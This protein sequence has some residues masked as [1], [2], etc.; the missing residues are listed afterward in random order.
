MKAPSLTLWLVMFLATAHRPAAAQ[1]KADADSSA[2]RGFMDKVQQAYANARYLR[3]HVAYR[4]ANQGQPNHYLDSLSGEIEMD[5]GRSRTVLDGMETVSNGRYIIQVMPESR[6]I[7]LAPKSSGSASVPAPVASAQNPMP[8]LDSL[9][10]QVRGIRATLTNSDGADVFTLDLPAGQPYSRLRLMIDD[11]TGYFREVTYDLNTASL[12]GEDMID[13]PGHPAP[14]QSRGRIQILFSEYRRGQ[15]DDR[16]FSENNFFTR[17]A[18]HY[19]P[20]GRY[21]DYHIYL[22]SSNL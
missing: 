16:I 10:A 19:Q 4:Y 2:V 18:G 1:T 21:R 14:Y 15:F 13:R 20:A 9:F 7:Y 5:G 6:I 17:I 22:A 11:R 8:M 3:F 12:V